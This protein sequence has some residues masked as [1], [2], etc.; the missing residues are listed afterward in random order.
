MCF[1]TGLVQITDTPPPLPAI[2]KRLFLIFSL[3]M[4]W[5]QAEPLYS[6]FLYVIDH[7]T[8]ILLLYYI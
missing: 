1:Q 3:N 5:T 2:K 6:L 7:V 8:Y 4:G